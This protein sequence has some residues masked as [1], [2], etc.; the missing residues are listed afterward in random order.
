[1]CCD[2]AISDGYVLTRSERKEAAR[3]K[4]I[5]A[6]QAAKSGGNP[7]ARPGVEVKL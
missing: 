2:P 6:A 3:P 1:M 5:L 7:P 4:R